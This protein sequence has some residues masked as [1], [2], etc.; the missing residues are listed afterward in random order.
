M[1]DY[2][3]NNTVEVERR[4]L[5]FQLDFS[6]VKT[7]RS[8]I[9]DSYT[10]VTDPKDISR[11]NPYK[12][13]KF[14]DLMEYEIPD[15]KNT[16]YWRNALN[17][18]Y[19]KEYDTKIGEA[20]QNNIMNSIQQ[21]ANALQA[22]P[23]TQLENSIYLKKSKKTGR[24]YTDISE[25]VQTVSDYTNISSD[26]KNT[27][28]LSLRAS[29]TG[30]AVTSEKTPKRVISDFENLQ[31]YE[32]DVIM[33]RTKYGTGTNA[34]YKLEYLGFVTNVVSTT[35]S[36]AVDSYTLTVE[37][38]TKFMSASLTIKTASIG[39]TFKD[40]ETF[41]AKIRSLATHEFESLDTKSI[42]DRLLEEILSCT[43][44]P[45][46]GGDYAYTFDGDRFKVPAEIP[47]NQTKTN[48]FQHAI[49]VLSTVYFM[50]LTVPDDA[51]PLYQQ[52]GGGKAKHLLDVEARALISQT[53]FKTYNIMA[54]TGF[55]LFYAQMET[56][57]GI[58]ADIRDKTFNDVFE[59]R[60]G[61][62]ICRGPRYNKMTEPENALKTS[63]ISIFKPHPELPKVA[64]F[65][66][67]TLSNNYIHTTQF[68]SQIATVRSDAELETHTDTMFET[69]FKRDSLGTNFPMGTYI[70]PNM[71]VR[72]GL[73]LKGPISNPNVFTPELA[74]MFAPIQQGILNAHTRGLIMRVKDDKPYEVGKLYYIEPQ[75]TKNYIETDQ[76]GS[77]SNLN[78]GYVGYLEK[79]TINHNYGS[80]STVDLTFV[81]AR[82]VVYR[83]ISEILA[84]NNELVN[85][86]LMYMPD[87]EP[88]PD[89]D[90]NTKKPYPP[91]TLR[92]TCIDQAKEVLQL[93]KQTYDYVPMYRY[94]PTLFDLFL[95]LDEHPESL[96]QP[97]AKKPEPKGTPGTPCSRGNAVNDGNALY[98]LEIIGQPGDNYAIFG[99]YSIGPLSINR[100]L[101]YYSG[102][103]VDTPLREVTTL[104]ANGTSASDIIVNPDLVGLVLFPT[105]FIEYDTILNPI[106]VST[107]KKTISLNHDA[108]R[109]PFLIS[110]ISSS[111]KKY[112]FTQYLVNVLAELDLLTKGQTATTWLSYFVYEY[113]SR[114]LSLYAYNAKTDSYLL[115]G[116]TQPSKMWTALVDLGRNN[117]SRFAFWANNVFGGLINFLLGGGFTVVK[118]YSTLLFDYEFK[119]RKDSILKFTPPSSGTF[120]FGKKTGKFESDFFTIEQAK[121]I[122]PSSGF[123]DDDYRLP[124]GDLVFIN[125]FESEPFIIHVSGG[126]YNIKEVTVS[127]LPFIRVTCVPKNKFTPTLQILQTFS[128]PVLDPK[129]ETGFIDIS[130]KR[131]NAGPIGTPGLLTDLYFT[132]PY[133]ELTVE[134]MVNI[135]ASPW[136]TGYRTPDEC[137]KYTAALLE[138]L[139]AQIGVGQFSLTEQTV[140]AWAEKENSDH[141]SGVAINLVP[142]AISAYS[143][144][145]LTIPKNKKDKFKAYMTKN[146]IDIV[147]KRPI[148]VPNFNA[149]APAKPGAPLPNAAFQATANT[150]WPNGSPKTIDLT[151]LKYKDGTS[152][153][154]ITDAMVISIYAYGPNDPNHEDPGRFIDQIIANTPGN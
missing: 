61:T 87:L 103:Q 73:R 26:L 124:E 67:S 8:V 19:Q 107:D 115:Y 117:L 147:N 141:S 139:K 114:F 128:G 150:T 39:T 25:Y 86:Y 11:E 62:L 109:T 33:V 52:S 12:I 74:K 22:N 68:G 1:S 13:Q 7:L 9:P 4:F 17:S 98:A 78:P 100:N 123:N 92:K 148:N 138:K 70:E 84:A 85:F 119:N 45:I 65:D 44:T 58:L 122:S 55:A 57:S 104:T 24:Y 75:R 23:P 72:Y 102:A 142:E 43:P 145:D 81:M 14:V 56:A 95:F 108:V 54:R 133:A 99:Y 66:D 120:G 126:V 93:L 60:N 105:G 132:S 53:N 76:L 110:S 88:L 35:K 106:L 152:R 146:L 30:G 34:F 96:K 63:N 94:I 50:S 48:S 151:N 113:R 91:G 69:N 112:K 20:Y 18:N 80:V 28:S 90:P 29:D 83:P 140:R 49:F 21:T 41:L 59:N 27:I 131:S 40:F 144:S 130:G 51:D 46:G 31:I 149:K 36:G 32:N 97:P 38:M 77:P 79:A 37:G 71:L 42:F 10:S 154:N 82:E 121:S 3:F 136:Y 47:N 16:L 6:K 2:Q 89:V 5:L 111:P 135:N 127:G 129:K 15:E 137:K 153:A 125:L 143:K 134:R 118:N 101:K 116:Q 64:V